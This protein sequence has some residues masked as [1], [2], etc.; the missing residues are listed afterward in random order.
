MCPIH[1]QERPPTGRLSCLCKEVPKPC[2]G[3]KTSSRRKKEKRPKS[4]NLFTFFAHHVPKEKHYKAAME[5]KTC[6]WHGF[7]FGI[8]NKRLLVT[9]PVPD[10]LSQTGLHWG[11]LTSFTHGKHCSLNRLQRCL[12]SKNQEL[13]ASS[14]TKPHTTVFLLDPI[15]NPAKLAP[16]FASGI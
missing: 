10:L 16:T 6:L 7:G 4:S 13:P 1:P 9:T 5:A 15:P 11:E 3:G 12:A 8:E 2:N 14:N